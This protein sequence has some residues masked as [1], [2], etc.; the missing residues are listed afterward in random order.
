M[1][2]NDPIEDL[3]RNEV[4]NNTS[5]DKPRDI[6]WK[7]IA[8]ELPSQKKAPIKD[9]VQ[10]VW[11]A[12][13]VFGLIVVP[14]IY[15]FIENLNSQTN[16]NNLDVVNQ[17]VKHQ[18]ETPTQQKID[19]IN[20]SDK[21]EIIKPEK[22]R[23]EIV[24]NS[25]PVAAKKSDVIEQGIEFRNNSNN[26]IFED[27]SIMIMPASAAAAIAKIDTLNNSIQDSTSVLL[28]KV[29]A[30]E[31]VDSVEKNQNFN[32]RS[33]TNQEDPKLKSSKDKIKKYRNKLAYNDK[34]YKVVFELVSKSE[35]SLIF[36]SGDVELKFTKDN[37][38]LLLISNSKNINQEIINEFFYRR[39][40]IFNYYTKY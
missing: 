17:I 12:A 9:F 13:A 22:D 4:V 7:K 1:I 38:Q 20:T 5:F 39:E 36:K 24:K 3:F 25:S 15:F 18:L 31:T 23:I 32:L 16:V 11:F 19:E 27:A 40:E 14:Y 29:S 34:L 37:N 6:V 26:P 28:A 35:N 2:P 30:L 21:V 8:N 33:S 10:S